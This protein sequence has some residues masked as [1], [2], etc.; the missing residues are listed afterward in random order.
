[1][2][3]LIRLVRRRRSQ[4][5]WTAAFC[6]FHIAGRRGRLHARRLLSSRRR[7]RVMHSYL[8]LSVLSL[9]ICGRVIVSYLQRLV[10]AL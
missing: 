7:V 3:L 5:L 10:M 4:R 1:M 2:Q 8:R 6:R 9:F